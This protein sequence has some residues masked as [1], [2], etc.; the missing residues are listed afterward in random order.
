LRRAGLGVRRLGLAVPGGVPGPGVAGGLRRRRRLAAAA[1]HAAAPRYADTV[2]RWL[3]KVRR[4]LDPRTGLIPHRADAETGAPAEMARGSS[5]S[6]IHRFL[7]DIDPAFAREQYLR[8]REHHLAFPLGLGPAVREYPHGVDGAGDVDSGPLLLGVSLSATTVALGAAQVN[9]DASLARALANYGELAGLPI[10]TP[11]TKR[12]AFGLLPIGDASW[13]GRRPHAH[14]SR[15]RR[16]RR[17]RRSPHGGACRC[18]R[19]SASA[20]PYRGCPTCCAAAPP[21]ARRPGDRLLSVTVALDGEGKAHHEAGAGGVI[22]EVQV[23]AVPLG[24]LPCDGQAQPGAAGVQP[25]A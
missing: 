5:Q 16:P 25:A 9:G 18:L 6:L 17:P 15:P 8:F 10:G 24:D 1:R 2:R 19:S 3:D 7:P 4:R 12:Y 11:W 23:T 13:P 21:A 22:G 14:G 20:V